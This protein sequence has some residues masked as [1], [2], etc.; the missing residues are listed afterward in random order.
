MTS[1]PVVTEPGPPPPA[2]LTK[3]SDSTPQ[4]PSQSPAAPATSTEVSD[5]SSMAIAPYVHPPTNNAAFLQNLGLSFGVSDDGAQP[6][7]W[8]F[9]NASATSM[10]FVSGAQL[11]DQHQMPITSSA[12]PF[13]GTV[14]GLSDGSASP[15]AL[16]TS[17]LNNG[18]AAHHPRSSSFTPTPTTPTLSTSRPTSV[19]I[20][21]HVAKNNP[22]LNKL[23]SMVDD[24]KTDDLIR[25]SDDGETFLVPNHERFGNEVLPRF[26]KH[27]RF[28][29]F[30]RQLNMYGFHKVPHLQQGALKTD[31][32]QE[33]ELWEFRN[34]NFKRDRPELLL[35]MQRKKGVRVEDEPS[36]GTIKSRSQDGSENDGQGTLDAINGALT[37]A[38]RGEG[39]AGLLQLVSVWNAIQA[40]QATQQGI[41]DNLRHLHNTNADL[42]REAAEQRARSKK[43][44]ET[45]NKMLRFLAGVFGAQDVNISGPDHRPDSPSPGSSNGTHGRGN[46]VLRPHPKGK[47][48]LLIG[49][50]SSIGGQIEELEVPVDD[51]DGAEGEDLTPQGRITEARSGTNSPQNGASPPPRFSDLPNTP[52]A[53]SHL[54]NILSD[55]APTPGGGRRISQQAGAQ[56]L[57]ALA[58]GEA[59]SWLANMFGQQQA[60]ASAQSPDTR[61]DNLNSAANGGGSFKLDSQT[62]AALQGILGAGAGSNEP[63]QPNGYFDG[64]PRPADHATNAAPPIWT[65]PN[66]VSPLTQGTPDHAQVALLNPHQQQ[67]Q[68]VT[69]DANVVQNAL[70]ALVEG[71]RIEN[72]A[73]NGVHADLAAQSVPPGTS[74]TSGLGSGQEDANAG[75]D[76]DSLLKEFFNENGATPTATTNDLPDDFSGQTPAFAFSPANTVGNPDASN[77]SR[78]EA[79]SSATS[80][81]NSPTHESALSNGNHS[82]RKRKPADDLENTEENTAVRSHGNKS[83]STRQ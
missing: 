53:K 39:E 71:L 51:D 19:Q 65:T 70:N 79:Q 63:V 48:R 10:P 12:Q 25:W 50:G 52:N 62:L 60:G 13:T 45:I 42:W 5:P 81:T 30:V 17:A 56:L 9:G 31:P 23:R 55:A 15:Q 61:N 78:S 43:Q 18:N 49:D 34:E 38:Q 69:Q 24:P 66:A 58:S 41:N 7:M 1:T 4:T 75:V 32:G 40:I 28:S 26:F 46:V 73:G 29:S 74:A 27:N 82:S 44:E 68:N 36:N 37:R 83:K 8:E 76:M 72:Q 64:A 21:T 59:Q 35:Q 80:S 20:P 14:G 47:R 2:L 57:N 16:F 3:H 67:L 54:P 22:F 6:S 77:P 11:A 33:T